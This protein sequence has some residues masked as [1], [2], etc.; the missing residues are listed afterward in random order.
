MP[1]EELNTP[2]LKLLEELEQWSEQPLK[3]DDRVRREFV[4]K[5]RQNA[6]EFQVLADLDQGAVRGL[7]AKVPEKIP[8]LQVPYFSHDIHSLEGLDHVRRALFGQEDRG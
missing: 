6:T 4:S 1:R 7:R 5:M 3:G 8:I 2:S